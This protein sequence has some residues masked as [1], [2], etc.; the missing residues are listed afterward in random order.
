MGPRKRHVYSTGVSVNEN[1][2]NLT[3]HVGLV[4]RGHHHII[5][6]S[7]A[8]CSRLNIPEKFPILRYIHVMSSFRLIPFSESIFKIKKRTQNDIWWSPDKRELG[9]T[10]V[11]ILKK[12]E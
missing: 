4:Q 3:N 7:N 10:N 5:I 11:Y 1:Y 8:I 12:T 2:K 9:I 6:S